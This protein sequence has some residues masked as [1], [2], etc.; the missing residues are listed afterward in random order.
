MVVVAMVVVVVVQWWLSEVKREESW[1]AM[2][3]KRRE[4]EM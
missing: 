2:N 1:D 3:E 4:V